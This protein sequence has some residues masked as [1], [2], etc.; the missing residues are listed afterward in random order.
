MH[1]AIAILDFGSQTA[2]LIARRVRE[3]QVYCELFPWNA[4][5]ETVLSIRPKGFILSGGPASV[6]DPGSPQLSEYVLATGLPILGICYGMQALTHALGGRVAQASS[7]EFGLAHL[8]SIQPNPLLPETD[9]AVWMSHGD[10]IDLAPAGFF[11]L[12][13]SDNSPV[14]AMGDPQR[15][16]YGVQFHPEVRHTAFGK[17]ILQAF[18]IEICQARP[19]WTPAAILQ[20]AVETVRQQ[21]GRQRVLSAVSGGVDSSVATALVQRA[22]GDQ[23]SAVFVDT[24]LL[25]LGEREQVIAAF[26][27]GL[28]TEIQVVDAADEFMQ[29]I[30]SPAHRLFS[31]RGR[32]TRTSSSRARRTGPRPPGSRPTTTSAGCPPR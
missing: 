8:H 24:G 6:Y 10:R 29:A 9:Q 30:G 21:V 2:Q 19:D 1:D 18:V 28:E 15:G 23:L 32:S 25:R 5:A 17:E 11:P 27:S 14:A 22:V 13:S 26:R 7:R 31:S 20:E 3:A 16:W 12:A 4:P